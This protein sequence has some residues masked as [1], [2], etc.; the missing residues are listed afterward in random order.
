MK[1]P[2]L[3]RLMSPRSGRKACFQDVHPAAVLRYNGI[4]STALNREAPC[5]IGK[6]GTTELMGLEYLDRRIQLRWP[7]SASW[8]RPAQRLYMCSGVF[9]VAEKTFLAWAETYRASLSLLDVVGQWQ[10][11]NTY[12]AKYEDACLHEYA[13]GAERC[14]GALVSPLQPIA[15]WVQELLAFRWLVI[16][17]FVETAKSQLPRL[18][19]LGIYP[20]ESADKLTR[21]RKTISFLASPP[22]AYMQPPQETD[23][24]TTLNKM[25]SSMGKMDFDLA[26]IGAGAWSLPLAAHAKAM[27][28][29]AIHLGGV[30]QLLLGIRGGRYDQSGIYSRDNSA[31]RNPLPAETP[32][33]CGLME[34][35]AYW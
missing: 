9:P 10:P 34:N 6:V 27:G 12:L 7:K 35:G 4:I 5:A 23:W 26:L 22:F 25:K 20:T 30:T 24:M 13:P 17:P 3:N 31:W 28:K 2:R 21:L 33:N 19:S 1:L 16:T 32:I 29:K 11:A 15:P 8:E 14:G 18:P